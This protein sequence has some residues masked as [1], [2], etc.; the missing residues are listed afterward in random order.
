MNEEERAE[1]ASRRH[2]LVHKKI[3]GSAT[4]EEMFE[5]RVLTALFRERDSFD[6]RVALQKLAL[7]A[8]NTERPLPNELRNLIEAIIEADV[9]LAKAIWSAWR[10]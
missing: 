2:A 5:Y 8:V 3:D 10:G 1:F 9:V 7:V 6:N 4:P